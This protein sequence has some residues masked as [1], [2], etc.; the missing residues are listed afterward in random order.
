MKEKIKRKRVYPK[1]SD[2][3]TLYLPEQLDVEQ[4]RDVV[5]NGINFPYRISDC[6]RVLILKTNSIAK[7][8]FDQ[9]GYPQI[10][11][12]NKGKRVGKRVHILVGKAFLENPNNLPELNHLDG[13]KLYPHKSNLEFITSKGNTQHAFK[14]G[15]KKP[16]TSYNHPMSKKVIDTE[17]GEIYPSGRFVTSKFGMKE[18]CLH[19]KLN[20]KRKNNTRFVYA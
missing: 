1:S 20:G 11:L 5:I 13:N 8:S 2:L 9:R 7:P 18:N 3:Q 15:L 6:G 4:W 19:P 10:V 16:Y 17:S 14:I 12:T